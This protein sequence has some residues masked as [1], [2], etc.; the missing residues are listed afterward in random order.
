MDIL[1]S[2]RVASLYSGHSVNSAG[3]LSVIN[4]LKKVCNMPDL[5]Y[6]GRNGGHVV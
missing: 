6:S 3:A 4:S 1:R 2:K 5:L